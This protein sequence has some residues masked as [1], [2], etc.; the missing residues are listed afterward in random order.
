MNIVKDN[1]PILVD[2]KKHCCGCG[3]C[4]SI[5]PKKAIAMIKDNE[6]FLYPEIN[7]SMCICCLQCIN[8]CFFKKDQKIKNYY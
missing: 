3:A 6:G 2:E 4:Y 7:E 8:V 5:C 1:Y